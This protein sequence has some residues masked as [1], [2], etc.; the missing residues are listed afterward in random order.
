MGT[1]VLFEE[2]PLTRV[3]TSGDFPDHLLMSAENSTGRSSY[4]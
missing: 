2:R 1:T 4:A 3:H